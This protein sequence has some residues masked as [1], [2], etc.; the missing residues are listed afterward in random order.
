MA[1]LLVIVSVVLAASLCVARWAAVSHPQSSPMSER[2]AIDR[3]LHRVGKSEYNAFRE[4]SRTPAGLTEQDLRRI[5]FSRGEPVEAHLL[6]TM[7]WRYA[8][9]LETTLTGKVRV[10]ARYVMLFRR[11]IGAIDA[12]SDGREGS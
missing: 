6:E 2:D 12:D 5:M 11:Q 4:L 10:R 7:R 1:T 9:L 3:L 8:P